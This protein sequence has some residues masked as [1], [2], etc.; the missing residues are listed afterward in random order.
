MVMAVVAWYWIPDN[1]GDARWLNEDEAKIARR[2]LLRVVDGDGDVGG[3]EEEGEEEERGVNFR[4]VVEAL[5]DGKNW[6]TA[7]SFLSRVFS[8][9][10]WKRG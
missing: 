3:Y 9:L 4:Q 7:V 1:P 6:I 8:L 2:R 10:V 5:R